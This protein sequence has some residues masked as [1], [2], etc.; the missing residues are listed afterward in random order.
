[1][2]CSVQM[3]LKEVKS[4]VH[5]VVVECR[6]VSVDRVISDGLNSH[7]LEIIPIFRSLLFRN[8]MKISSHTLPDDC[9]FPPFSVFL[10][11]TTL[12]D[13]CSGSRSL[14]IRG[15]GVKLTRIFSRE[16]VRNCTIGGCKF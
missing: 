9:T 6:G 16:D 2:G 15:D 4:T 12:P 3:K 14:W 10:K 11:R 13:A 1:M 8:P 5:L 7:I